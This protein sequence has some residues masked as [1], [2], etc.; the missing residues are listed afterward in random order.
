MDDLEVIARARKGDPKA[1]RIIVE[2]YADMV[3][4][5]MM[6]F[7]R[8]DRTMAEDLAQKVFLQV[9]KSLDDFR[10]PYNLKSWILKIA[11]NIGIDYIRGKK[12]EIETMAEY[13]DIFDSRPATP[14]EEFLGRECLGLVSEVLDSESDQGIRDTVIAF[15]K[16]RLSV[17]RISE[18]QGISQTSVT[19]R[20]S[21]FRGRLKKRMAK[22]ALEGE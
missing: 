17:Q 14:E 11:N 15:Y 20:L 9:F 19:S 3:F 6:K 18:E 7:S 22:M 5:I 16:R 10:S 21:R 12:R 2:R 8:Q 13:A 4:A 1:G